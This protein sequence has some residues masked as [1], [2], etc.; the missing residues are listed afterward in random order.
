MKL[1]I[2]VREHTEINMTPKEFVKFM[3]PKVGME[4]PFED[5]KACRKRGYL[6]FEEFLILGYSKTPRQ[7]H[8]YNRN[9]PEEVENITR[10][11]FKQKDLDS[12]ILK[13]TELHGIDV[14]VA[15]YLLTAWN[16]KDYGT[17][18]FRMKKILPKCESFK[19]PKNNSDLEW[20]KAELDLLRKWRNELGIETC[21]QVEY[22][23]WRFQQVTSE[24]EKKLP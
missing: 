3:A 24:Y 23:L 9:E 1:K 2:K 11:A 13:L 12:I 14:P 7:W 18:D 21:R 10:E 22:A 6:T 20:Y 17:L 4:H 16:P 5:V 15:S 8:Q 19:K